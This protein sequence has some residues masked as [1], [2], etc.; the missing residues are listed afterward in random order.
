MEK[1]GALR[2]AAI[3]L[4]M[5][6]AVFIGFAAGM[7]GRPLVERF[8]E[9]RETTGSMVEL[10]GPKG[11]LPMTEARE[12]GHQNEMLRA[13]AEYHRIQLRASDE[14]A[15]TAGPPLPAKI[16]EAPPRA[17]PPSPVTQKRKRPTAA[18]KTPFEPNWDAPG[19]IAR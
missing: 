18:P 15:L 3:G 8:F 11:F 12:S 10:E 7:Y 14:E 4:V 13:L 5:V 1:F 2:I 19:Y 6:G 9:T 16:S 17:T